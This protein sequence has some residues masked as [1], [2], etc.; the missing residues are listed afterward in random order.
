MEKVIYFL[1]ILVTIY[2]MSVGFSYILLFLIAIKKVEKEKDLNKDLYTNEL[3][4]KQRTYPVSIIVPAYNEELG[5][6]STVRSLLSLNY[7]DF[8]VIVVDDGSSD[9]TAEAM[10]DT[11]QMKRI[12]PAIRTHLE[13]KEILAVY[14]STIFDDVILVRKRNGGKADAL[15]A[16]INVSKYPYFCAIDGDSILESDSLIKTMKPI[17]ESNGSVIVA[18]GSIRIANGCKISKSKVE[19][20]NLPKQPIVIM[21]IIEY[22]RGFLIGRIGLSRLN[23]LLIISGAFGIFNKDRVIRAGGYNTRTLGEDMEL[24]VRIHRLLQEEKSKERIEY[25]P[26]PVC[27]TEAPST[28]SVLHRQRL[29]WQRGLAETLFIHRKMIFNPKYKG[30]GMISLPYFLIVELCSGLIEALGYLIIIF[31]LLFSFIDTKIALFMFGV[32]IIY[33]SLISVLSV[34]LEEWTFHKYPKI[35]HLLK[36]YVWALT[37]SFW[38]RPLLLGAKIEGMFSAFKKKKTWGE[39][40]RKGISTD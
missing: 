26:D 9:R 8:E 22:F 15:N 40:E 37:E 29:R 38:Y 24:V 35:S 23:I 16:G 3:K 33:G 6:T 5:V 17:V 1:T 31:G 20:I 10:I 30:I 28:F 19:E 25:I 18:G 39:M 11:F 12:Y 4:D 2:M 14:Q 36:L 7:P 32:T 21:Q 13:T 27:W 34:L